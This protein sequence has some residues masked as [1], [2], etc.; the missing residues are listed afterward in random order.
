MLSIRG[1]TRP[2]L[3]PVDL[4][5]A[6]GECVAVLGPSGAGKTLLLRAIADLDPNQGEAS[7]GGEPRSGMSGPAWRRRV[8]YLAAESGWW[9]DGVGAHFA[10]TNEAA[11]I[12]A[13]LGLPA[14][15]FGW[16]VARASTGERQRL[17]LA[18]LLIQAPEVMLLDE[19]SSGL[20]AEA[21]ARVEALIRERL[22]AGAAALIATHDPALAGRMAARRL[23]VEG[24]K[25]TEASP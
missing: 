2:G 17:A 19:P 1:L 25:V 8:G 11:P 13:A 24:G 20:D 18:R 14:E 4:D 6:A 12:I 9:A 22:A 3:G 7:L 21:A 15:V 23:A 5:L 10:D 16:Q